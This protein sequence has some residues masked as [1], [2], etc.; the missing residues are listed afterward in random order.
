MSITFNDID[1]A[2]DFEPWRGPALQDVRIVKDIYPPRI[3]LDFSLKNAAGAEIAGGARRLTD[4]NFMNVI[5]VTVFMNDHLRHEKMLLFNWLS[6]E[7]ARL[8][9]GGGGAAGAVNN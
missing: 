7:V 9:S 6:G 4:M 3:A 8:S 1:M 5:P 2:G